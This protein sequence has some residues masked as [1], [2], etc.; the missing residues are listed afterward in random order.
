ML[1]DGRLRW[2]GV[3]VFTLLV[4][5]LLTGWKHYTETARQRALASHDE[6]ERW[7]TQGEKNPHS[8]AHYGVYAFKPEQPLS[9]LDQGL[10][11]YLGVAVWL[12]AHKQNLFKF[13]PAEDSTPISRF[14]E[15]TAAVTLQMLIPLLIVLLLHSAF[16]GER[17]QGTLRLLMSLGA[18]VRKLVYGKALGVTIVLGVLLFPAASIGSGAMM[19]S[20]GAEASN[21]GAGRT[22]V[23][24]L[25]YLT[26]FAIFIGL[27]LIVS[28][29]AKSSQIALIVL[30]AA[31]FLN[32][33]VAP[34]VITDFAA[35]LRPAPSAMQLA[36]AIERDLEMGLDGHS[37]R[38]ARLDELKARALKEYGVKTIEE[39][40]VNFSGIQLN[41]A[42]EYGYRVYDKHLNSLFDSYER[43]NGLYQ[44][45]SLLAPMLS[46]QSVSMGLAGTDFAQHRDFTVKAE[47]YR[48]SV[49]KLMSDAITY[50]SR[51]GAY[52]TAGNELWQQAPDFEYSAPG[53]GWVLSN[54]RWSL[55]I[56][57]FW[58]V[59]VCASLTRIVNRIRLD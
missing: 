3:I 4:A 5:S 53:L 1:R 40:P 36:S 47:E 18:P 2:A 57:C 44:S 9:A 10:N 39:L 43:Q 17:E 59:V 55:L 46:V 26:Y 38:G 49:Q 22:V 6:R 35:I 28:A 19:L 45:A 31:W 58:L 30:L 20:S 32:C 25:S 15:L 34:R 51:T 12:E 27:S 41:E 37:S 42:D 54:N 16:T 29:R 21:S 48:R 23:M 24:A 50:K 52:L 7:L 33:F 8:A 56:L 13:R 11:P 14:G